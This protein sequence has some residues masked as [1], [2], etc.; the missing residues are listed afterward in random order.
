MSETATQTPSSRRR[1]WWRRKRLWLP[2]TLAAVLVWLDGPGWRWLAR[3]AADHYLPG[4]GMTADFKLDGRLSGGDLR[5][6][7][8][9]ID[10]RTVVRLAGLDEAVVRY[11]PG[12]ILH[13]EIDSI[14]I[15]GLHA[16]IDLAALPE[17]SPSTA[18]EEE[19]K[20][21][22][23]TLRALH[24]R[25]QTVGLDLKDVRT[26]LRRGNEVLFEIEPTDLVHSPGSNRFTLRL[27]EARIGPGQ[28]L[29]AQTTE[30]DWSADEFTL[31]R[32]ELLPGIAAT[33]VGVR[34][35]DPSTTNLSGTLEIDDA[36]LAF[37]SNFREGTLKLSGDALSLPETLARFG[38]EIPVSGRLTSLEADL[39]GLDGGLQTLTGNASVGFKDLSHDGWEVSDALL[40]AR[41]GPS[42]FTARLSGT[43]LG[44]PVDLETKGTVTRTPTFRPGKIAGTLG[45]RETR[46]ALEFL[47]R[48]FMA[49]ENPADLPAAALTGSFEADFSEGWNPSAAAEIRLVPSASA[50][51]L[52][53]S[54]TWDGRTLATARLATPGLD[55]SGTFNTG[56]PGYSG[57]ASTTDFDPATLAPWLAPFGIRA[58]EGLR[59]TLTWTGS[60][61][62]RE[63]R[64]EGRL[65]VPAFTLQ[66]PDLAEPVSAVARAAYAWPE[67]LEVEAIE[68]RHASQSLRTRATLR[69]HRLTLDELLWQDGNLP[70][71]QG[72]AS[73]PVPGQPGDWK[74]ILRS[75]ENIEVSLAGRDLPL[76]RLHPFLP[77]AWRFRE[78]SRGSVGINL[79]GSPHTPELNATLNG[80]DLAFVGRDQVPAVQLALKA[81]GREQTLKVEGSL[82]T[83]DYPPALI[84]AVT[85]WDPRQWAEEP[86]TV[87]EA[88]LEASVVI[89]KLQLGLL[90]RFVPE[91]RRIA[92]EVNLRGEVGGTIGSPE[93]RAILTIDGAAFE[94]PDPSIPRLKDGQLRLN[95]TPEAVT[96]EKL[97]GML[98]GGIF[99]ASG[100]A[101]LSAGK[102]GDLD[103]S[104]NADA[105]PLA[106]NDSVVVRAS[107][108]LKLSG[109]LENARIAGSV[110][111][112]DSVF[113]RDFEILPIG[114]PITNVAEPRL[115][116]V[117]ADSPAESLGRIPAPFRDWTLDLTAKTENPFL[118]RGNLGN[119]EI[120]L[121][122]RIGGTLGSPRPT[123]AAT[124]RE[125]S[126]Q[127]PFSTLDIR[128]GRIVLRPDAP[129][130]PSLEIRG[131]SVIRP[132]E[133]DLYVYGSLSD[134][135]IQTTSNPP[136]PESEVLTLLA[137]GATSEGVEDSS[138]ASARAAQLL[139]E[140]VRRG[141]VE[142]ARGL[143]PL[144]KV[145]DKVDFQVGERDP[146]SNRK[147]NSASF[148][149]S[150]E[151]LLTA[152]FSEEG[153]TRAK[154]TYLIRFR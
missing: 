45:I 144:L 89:E 148:Q 80:T 87:R 112:V 58:P 19:P 96:L 85:R 55:A 65:E 22:A 71:L 130:D 77:E 50:P 101:K 72:R 128:T 141:R 82:T 116:A 6:S 26:T 94:T 36:R 81:S 151:W 149:L 124:L 143:R 105:L 95:A 137:S 147:F 103:F 13:G 107:S 132:Y 54:G 126:A 142:V 100:S 67:S 47:R 114:A 138:A 24:A 8:V 79:T 121:D 48:R 102:V 31:D 134:P 53:I 60:G 135:R 150:D 25:W 28:S 93:P 115:P 10:G 17:K 110:T 15:R 23:A 38:I 30:I 40:T 92:G 46:P 123:G 12:R 69:E 70:L 111:I 37:T 27:G 88:G 98:S 106:R 18:R 56:S 140:E 42:D 91:A 29:P 84:D 33:G 117:D 146:Y 7:E 119:G 16:D 49:L 122:A 120:Y 152:G 35:P 136:L 14:G 4:L 125:I 118:I 57:S 74:A 108:K 129:F 154:V 52:E 127:L 73:I 3:K 153:R 39:A 86:E 21:L 61:S 99:E 68:L 1:P 32:L 131:R 41:L 20:D 104:L 59:G 109:D 51:P 44:S 113:Y 11:R 34:F 133:V 66:R 43:G 78:N 90:S 5:V 64:H 76:S 9:K 63:N 83:S 75:Q 139:I 2:L 62:P 97:S 145:L